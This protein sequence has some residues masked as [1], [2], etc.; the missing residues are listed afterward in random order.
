M[1]KLGHK[2]TLRA[3]NMMFAWSES[4][5]SWGGQNIRYV[6]FNVYS[7]SSPLEIGTV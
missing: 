6:P 2:P 4:R 5:H 1:S 7:T 3:S